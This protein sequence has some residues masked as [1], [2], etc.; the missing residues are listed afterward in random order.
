MRKKFTMDEQEAAAAVTGFVVNDRS[1]PRSLVDHELWVD[2][3]EQYL[4]KCQNPCR[5]PLHGVSR[6]VLGQST[7]GGEKTVYEIG[8]EWGYIGVVECI[9]FC[10]DGLFGRLVFR[11]GW[12]LL[13][14]DFTFVYIH[15]ILDMVLCC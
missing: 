15:G 2:F 10:D 12:R 1:Y 11:F 13:V 7:P 5:F 4:K 14:R 9:Y 6:K 3:G 8:D